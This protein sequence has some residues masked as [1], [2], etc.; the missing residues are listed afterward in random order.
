MTDDMATKETNDND[1]IARLADKG[2]QAIH[3][4]ADLP[5][6][7]RALKGFNDLKERVDDLSKRMRGIDALEKRIAKLEKDM[8]ALRR[9]QKP[10]PERTQTRK[11]AP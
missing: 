3:R 8:A 2:E 10:S 4:L 7:S 11:A 6:A 5:G 1:A 9:A